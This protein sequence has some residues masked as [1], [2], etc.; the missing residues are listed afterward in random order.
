MKATLT[1]IALLL[2]TVT[3]S[4]ARLGET[5]VGLEARYGKPLPNTVKYLV[6]PDPKNKKLGEADNLRASCY[7][8]DGIGIEVEFSQSRSVKE[9]Y[10]KHRFTDQDI[11]ALLKANSASQ[12][13]KMVKENTSWIRTDGATADLKVEAPNAQAEKDGGAHF[14]IES[15]GGFLVLRDSTGRTIAG[16]RFTFVAAPAGF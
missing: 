10:V 8:K 3:V 11:A 13:W 1:I 4:R 12:Q 7:Q 2:L 9:T 16:S 5:P 14:R 6:K 15:A